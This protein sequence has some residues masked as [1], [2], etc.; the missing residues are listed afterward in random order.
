MKES[1]IKC[2][3]CGKVFKKR[4]KLNRHIKETHTDIKPYTCTECGADFKRNS[5]LTRHKNL[6][7]S[8]ENK[9]FVCSIDNCF[10]KF[11]IKQ[12]LDRHIKTIHFGERLGCEECGIFFNKKTLFAKH[13]STVHSAPKPFLC[14][15]EDC[16]KGFF[17][18][19]DLRK[20]EKIVHESPNDQSTC[21]TTSKKRRKNIEG[22]STTTEALEKASEFPDVSS[23][24]LTR[25]K[26]GKQ[27]YVCF[28]DD[29][30]KALTSVRYS[31]FK[32][33]L[34]LY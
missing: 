27:V 2:E 11:S 23:A 10:Q 24:K 9:S 21:S 34:N 28:Y 4:N 18:E 33:I 30:L 13:I 17:R 8:D 12:H 29:C 3:E 5:H 7:H 1:D 20:H 15:V 22:K 32:G 26:S 14:P 16:G 6:K 31:E 19:T 25:S